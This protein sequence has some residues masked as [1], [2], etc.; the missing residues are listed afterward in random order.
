MKTILRARLLLFMGYC[1]ISTSCG[2]SDLIGIWSR[3]G[4]GEYYHIQED[5]T[6]LYAYTGNSSKSSASWCYKVLELPTHEFLSHVMASPEGMSVDSGALMGRDDGPYHYSKVNQLPKSC[7]DGGMPIWGDADFEGSLL[8]DF[9]LLWHSFDQF[10][11]YFGLHGIDWSYQYEEIRQDIDEY[12]TPENFIELMA[13]VFDDTQDVHIG[14]TGESFQYSPDLRLKGFTLELLEAFEIQEEFDDFYE[15]AINQIAN[16]LPNL[17]R[18]KYIK[19]LGEFK[20]STEELTEVEELKFLW[21]DFSKIGFAN[22]AYLSIGSFHTTPELMD[23]KVSA[24]AQALK[25]LA[26]YDT[27]VIDVRNNLGGSYNL[28]LKI[29]GFFVQ[30]PT[31]VFYK[32]AYAKSKGSTALQAVSIE[33]GSIYYRNPVVILQNG[34]STSAAETFLLAMHSLYGVTLIG[35]NS[36]GALASTIQRILPYSGIEVSIPNEVFLSIEDSRVFEKEGV[37][38]DIQL[39]DQRLEGEDQML[40]KAINLIQSQVFLF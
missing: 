17:T 39:D 38:A 37:V 32:Q 23:V 15:Y 20:G 24:I 26:P 34:L 6:V 3:E 40:M 31:Q 18:T 10:Y 35:E 19:A 14:L 11:P 16:E 22:I 13:N 28:A 12:T 36:Q 4:Y 21:G 8:S 25:D 33:P 2:Y 7:S 30:E 27:L 5:R 9:E 29:A 1:G